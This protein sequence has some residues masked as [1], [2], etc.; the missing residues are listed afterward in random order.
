V[1]VLAWTVNRRGVLDRLD[2]LGVDGVITDDPGIFPP[3]SRATL[4]V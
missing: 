2:R 4:P 1:P 3:G